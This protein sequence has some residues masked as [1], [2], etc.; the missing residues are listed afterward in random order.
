M[1]ELIQF[2]A[3]SGWLAAVETA[4]ESQGLGCAEFLRRCVA[5]SLARAG[6]KIP[7]TGRGR[8]AERAA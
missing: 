2:R 8:A 1:P 7:G 4:A 6:V 3:E 5:R